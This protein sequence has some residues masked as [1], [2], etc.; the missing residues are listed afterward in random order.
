MTTWMSF[1]HDVDYIRYFLPMS[2]SCWY[3]GGYGDFQFARNVDFIE[4]LVA[5]KRLY[6]RGYFIYHAVGAQDAVKS[7]SIGMADEMLRRGA[8][9]RDHYMF[10]QKDGGYHD[11]D[12]VRFWEKQ[13]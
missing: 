13:L 11:L 9:T 5:D 2:G 3:Y 8:F 12:A 4:Q 6:E 10:Y 7:Q 1:C